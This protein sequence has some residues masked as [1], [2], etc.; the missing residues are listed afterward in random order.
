MRRRDLIT[1]LGAAAA[2]RD[3]M[4]RARFPARGR[5]RMMARPRAHGETM[6]TSSIGGTAK[7]LFA[8]ALGMLLAQAAP[9]QTIEKKDVKL[10][11]G[12]KAG[13]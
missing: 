2:A 6:A 4:R 7:A 3:Q 9:A 10:G 12:G 8:L 1:L 11:V 5:H 13:L